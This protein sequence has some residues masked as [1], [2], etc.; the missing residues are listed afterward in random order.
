V[1]VADVRHSSTVHFYFCTDLELH[2]EPKLVVCFTL[3][4]QLIFVCILQVLRYSYMYD[5]PI[6]EVTFADISA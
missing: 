6:V 1:V 2:G 5:R 4:I 3:Y